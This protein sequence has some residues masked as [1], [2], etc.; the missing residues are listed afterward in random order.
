MFD[1]EEDEEDWENRCNKNEE[2]GEQEGGPWVAGEDEDDFMDL[3]DDDELDD[4]EK[5]EGI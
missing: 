2:E 4:E 3:L 5:F 1:G